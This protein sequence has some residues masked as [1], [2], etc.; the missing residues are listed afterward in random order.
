MHLYLNCACEHWPMSGESPP[1]G[2][3]LCGDK[4]EFVAHYALES[5]SRLLSTS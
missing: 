2:L 1:V 4:D 5:L 3:I